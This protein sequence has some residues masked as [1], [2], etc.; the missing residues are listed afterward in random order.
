MNA[1]DLLNRL[2]KAAETA[3]VYIENPSNEDSPLPIGTPRMASEV[4]LREG[5]RTPPVVVVPA[6]NGPT[7]T[8]ARVIESLKQLI[9]AAKPPLGTAE[10]CIN[11]GQGGLIPLESVRRQGGKIIFAVS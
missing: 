5:C 8:T 2:H 11:D 3:P 6:N 1:T 4:E 9:R 10:V 7:M